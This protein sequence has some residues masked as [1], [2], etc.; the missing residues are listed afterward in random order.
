[1]CRYPST[2]NDTTLLPG[3]ALVHRHFPRVRR[4]GI[5]ERLATPEQVNAL[6]YP[7]F[8]P[9]MHRGGQRVRREEP[10]VEHL[11]ARRGRQIGARHMED[12]M[13]KMHPRPRSP[14]PPIEDTK[15]P[16]NLAA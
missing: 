14:Q 13:E 10:G 7:A 6:R 3:G 2:M 1:M 9:A 5:E 4:R 12:E 15:Q 8:V 11:D 16:P